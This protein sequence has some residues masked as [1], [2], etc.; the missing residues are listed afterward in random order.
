VISKYAYTA[1]L[2]ALM[3]LQAR[4]GA[5]QRISGELRVQVMDPSGAALQASGVLIGQATGVN[6]TFATDENGRFTLRGLPLG[7]YQLTTQRDGFAPQSEVI[8]I[9][10]QLPIE[11]PITLRISPLTTTVEVREADTLLDPVRTAQYLPSQVL[12]DRPSTTPSRAIPGLVNTQPG[13]LLEANGVLHPR[14]SEYD[15]QYVIDGVPFYDNRSPAFA[16]SLNVEEFQSLNVRTS[17]YPAEFGLKLGGVIET[18]NDKDTPA[19]LHGAVTLGGG[20]FGNA[21]GSASVQ[22]AH[23]RTAVGVTGE[24]MMTDRYLDPPV[25]QN[26]TNHGSGGGYSAVLEHQWSNSDRTRFSADHHDTRFTVPNELIQEMAGQRQDRTA[27]ETLGQVSHTHIFSTHVL[28]QFRAMARDTNTL[29]WSNA[30]ST[31]IRPFQDR[32]FREGYVAGSVS[33]HYGA[34]ELK[35][36]V[37]STF[38]SVHEDLGFHIVTYRLNGIRIFDRDIPQDFRFT[39]S[40]RG[41][42]QSAF[43]QDMWRIGRL[44]VSAGLRFDHYKL[45]ADE[46]A[47]SPRLGVAYDVPR[48]GLVL[49][50][51]YDRIFQ[52]PA[53]ENILLASSDQ[54][55]SLGGEGAF[56]PLKPSRGN[57]VETGFSKSISR[58]VRLDGNWYRRSFENFSDDSLLL[59]TGISFPIAFS[60]ATIRGFETKI[61][62]HGLGPFSGQVSYSNMIGSGRLPVAGG[63]FLGDEADTLL[64]GAGSFPV[65]QDQ[66]NTFRSRIRIQAHRRVWFA[67]ANSY[68]SG[69]P[70]EIEG[71]SSPDFIA[72]QYGPQILAH[73]NEERG[74]ILPSASFDVSAGVDLVHSDRLRLRAQFDAFNLTNRLNLIN[75]SGVFSGTALD[76]PRNYAVRLRTEF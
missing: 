20:S 16:Q 61:D 34:H 43:V 5:A 46:T 18:A 55:R 7:R 45:V 73:I 48:A 2:A 74:R 52:I 28:A 72:E 22:Y 66:R 27:G 70:F 54:V 24:A 64:N 56:L 39:D 25:E 13:W 68:N 71:P 37:E 44:N 9:R 53:V 8:E 63:L 6:R 60:T 47:W 75:F 49:R 76:A 26:Y 14:G 30:L 62:V 35:A 50:G 42:T 1:L 51:S 4:T 12:E 67:V 58:K 15:V 31:P 29:F 32:G 69:L 3:V 21:S 38:S 41:R 23:R 59:N 57:F 36:G 65:S 19:G 17:G 11:H 10:S 40:N 33:A